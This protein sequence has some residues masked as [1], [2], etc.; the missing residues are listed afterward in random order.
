M[1][2][3]VISLGWR[4]KVGP[5]LMGQGSNVVDNAFIVIRNC[6]MS[7]T[8]LKLCYIHHHMISFIWPWADFFV[9]TFF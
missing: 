7:K 1:G 4:L 3:L 6:I 9:Y 8:Q 5:R 2:I